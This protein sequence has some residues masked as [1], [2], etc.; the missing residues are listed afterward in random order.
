MKYV[1]FLTI[2]TLNAFAEIDDSSFVNKDRYLILPLKSLGLTD[3]I[4]FEI[5]FVPPAGKKVNKASFIKIYEKNSKNWSLTETVEIENAFEEF[6]G[7]VLTH[8]SI[9]KTK[10]ALVGVE[11]DFIHCDYAGRQCD[12][13][14]YI[15]KINRSKKT[16]DNKVKYTLRIKK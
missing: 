3:S 4:N 16:K 13:E 2:L 1:L 7:R 6:D 8:N 11:I 14:R 9:L 10:N 5:E 12:Q 15:G